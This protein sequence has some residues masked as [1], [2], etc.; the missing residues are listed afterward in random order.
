[1]KIYVDGKLTDPKLVGWNN[2][3]KYG[4]MQRFQPNQIFDYS[5][6][7]STEEFLSEFSEM[8]AEQ[9]AEFKE[10]D[11]EE[12]GEPT[13]FSEFNYGSLKDALNHPRALYVCFDDYMMT[14]KVLPH[15][16][17]DGGRGY[18]INSLDRLFVTK[19][20]KCVMLEGRGWKSW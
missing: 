1:M 7:F 16:W 11:E 3:M 12:G 6:M 19:D 13:E 4:Q 9:A 20:G 10:I 18:I 8:F 17:P 5:M 15:F 14:D 2:H